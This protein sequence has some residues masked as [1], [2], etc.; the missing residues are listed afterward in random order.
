[1]RMKR[2][3]L[4]APDRWTVISYANQASATIFIDSFL[5]LGGAGMAGF[6]AM[7]PW[8]ILGWLGRKGG[9]DAGENKP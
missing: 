3:E 4:N 8:I 6:F 1:M 2:P 9:Q 7:L 5:G